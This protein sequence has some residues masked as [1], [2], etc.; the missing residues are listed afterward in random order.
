[1][2]KAA[3]GGGIRVEEVLVLIQISPLTPRQLTN[4]VLAASFVVTTADGFS[5]PGPAVAATA[6]PLCNAES[7]RIR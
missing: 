5:T 6:L 4:V 3:A 1:M 2:A 7:S